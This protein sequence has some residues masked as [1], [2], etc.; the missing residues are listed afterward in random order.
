M[1]VHVLCVHAYNLCFVCACVYVV[2]DMLMHL[3]MLHIINYL[4]LQG[5]IPDSEGSHSND[6]EVEHW[7]TELTLHCEAVHVMMISK[8]CSKNS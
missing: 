6:T 1:C 7:D 4:Q 3:N 2:C 8:R 5:S